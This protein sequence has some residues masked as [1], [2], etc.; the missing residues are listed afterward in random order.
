MKKKKKIFLIS[1]QNIYLKEFHF[2][3]F[4]L[5]TLQQVNCD[6]YNPVIETVTVK[7]SKEKLDQSWRNHFNQD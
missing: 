1:G 6:L 4:V 7:L 3:T 2:Y 5:F